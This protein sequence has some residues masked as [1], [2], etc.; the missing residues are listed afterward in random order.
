MTLRSKHRAWAF[1]LLVVTGACHRENSVAP[2]ND[3]AERAT[4]TAATEFQ[5]AP[6]NPCAWLSRPDV[7]RALSNELSAE[8]VRVSSAESPRPAPTGEAC[9][10]TLKD[11]DPLQPTIAMQVKADEPGLLRSSFER[12][13]RVESS[14]KPAD[15]AQTKS[16]DYFIPIPGGLAALGRGRISMVWTSSPQLSDKATL[17]AGVMLDHIADMPFTQDP[18]DPTSPATGRD[19]C[20]L[21]SRSEA[22][23]IL[24]P[25]KLAPFRSR[26]ASALAHASGAS[27]T[28]FTSQHRALIVTPKWSRAKGSF[29]M[30][31]A[32]STAVAQGIAS[33]GPPPNGPWDQ[34]GVGPD[35]ALLALKGDA[36]ISMQYVT[37]NIDATAAMQLLNVAYRRLGSSP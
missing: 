19:P 20:A 30:F 25:L 5:M 3:P 14:F 31:A 21:I 17:L 11:A 10:Y 26:K 22:E 12:M 1:A 7:E 36:M 37:A 27:C 6:E 4:A 23:R 13:G 28:Y 24:G 34:L 8:P 33:D 15:G 2:P 16:W 18:R 29:P 9:L 32:A 35:G